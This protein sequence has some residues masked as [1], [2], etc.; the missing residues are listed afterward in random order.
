MTAQT[1]EGKP[2]R[3]YRVFLTD[4]RIIDVTAEIVCEPDKSLNSSEVRV[5]VFKR[6]GVIVAKFKANDVN[7]WQVREEGRD[8]VIF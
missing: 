4:G 6:E 3:I 1:I 2:I 8:G 7:G 5:Y